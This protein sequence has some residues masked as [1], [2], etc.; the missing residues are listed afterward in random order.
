MTSSAS[1]NY[2]TKEATKVARS[3]T[4]R[5][6]VAFHY[7]N[8]NGLISR[9]ATNDRKIDELCENKMCANGAIM[10]Y[11]GLAYFETQNL[12]DLWSQKKRVSRVDY[13]VAVEMLRE[14]CEKQEKFIAET[15]E[16]HEKFIQ[17]QAHV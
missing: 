12:T 15:I 9:K 13:W 3:W 1:W 2:L 11:G 6:M 7:F 16:S 14:K 17:E 5:E 4:Y 10:A 8:P